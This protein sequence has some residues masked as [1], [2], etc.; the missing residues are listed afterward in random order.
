MQDL[1]A[2][3]VLNGF[4]HAK[5]VFDDHQHL[6]RRECDSTQL[7]QPQR[8]RVGGMLA[9]RPNMDWRLVAAYCGAVFIGIAIATTTA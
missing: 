2:G 5:I 9:D 1:V 4:G 6:N 3:A 7:R 8:I